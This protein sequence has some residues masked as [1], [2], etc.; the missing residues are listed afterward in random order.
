[1]LYEVITDLQDESCIAL[2]HDFIAR[3]PEVWNEDIGESG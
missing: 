1:M 2:M 3:K